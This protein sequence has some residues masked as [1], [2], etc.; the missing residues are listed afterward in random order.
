MVFSAIKKKEYRP[1]REVITKASLAFLP[2][3]PLNTWLFIFH[4]RLKTLA[5]ETDPVFWHKE[6]EVG[7]GGRNRIR[8]SKDVIP[9]ITFSPLKRRWVYCRECSLFNHSSITAPLGWALDPY[10]FCSDLFIL[11][12]RGIHY[13]GIFF[14]FYPNPEYQWY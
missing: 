12:E 7:G 5:S 9:C 4:T 8:F 1:E 10:V 6:E 14:F 13:K 3:T 2:L 11:G